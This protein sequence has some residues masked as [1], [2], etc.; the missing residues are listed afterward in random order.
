MVRNDNDYIKHVIVIILKKKNNYMRA[1]E[2]LRKS[3]NE[4]PKY[5]DAFNSLISDL[6]KKNPKWSRTS[7][8][9]QDL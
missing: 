4:N 5:K 3:R 9:D 6:R 8:D 2:A 7:V 1:L